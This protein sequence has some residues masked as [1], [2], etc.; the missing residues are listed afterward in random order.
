[1]AAAAG[2]DQAI[3]G[4]AVTARN[5]TIAGIADEL[6]APLDIALDVVDTHGDG[7]WWQIER[8]EHDHVETW[9]TMKYGA[10]WRKSGR[11]SDACVEGDAFDM[12]QIADAI[13][14]GSDYEAR[15]CAAIHSPEGYRFSSPR[16]SQYDA[17]VPHPRATALAAT[18]RSKVK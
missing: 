16:N 17:L 14:R 6:S 12:L 7:S 1:M 9:E 5:L 10:A 11:I 3:G 18:I 2:R 13:E 15:R 8:A 4:V